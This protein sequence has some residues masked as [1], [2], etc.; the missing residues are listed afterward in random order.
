MFPVASTVLERARGPEKYT[1]FDLAGVTVFNTG[2]D[3][4]VPRYGPIFKALGKVTFGLYDKPKIALSADAVSKLA[5]Y[6]ACWQSP[7]KG[8]ED[9]LSV[10][11]P[12]AALRRFLDLAKDR[13]DYP[14]HHA[15][16]AASMTD[17]EIKELAHKVLKDRKGESTQDT[18]SQGSSRPCRQWLQVRG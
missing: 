15:K 18:S 12:V 7:H 3:G 17:S 11:V 1:H 5:E 9:M 16:P 14:T 8:V 10:E 13:S 6:T 4:S 2:G